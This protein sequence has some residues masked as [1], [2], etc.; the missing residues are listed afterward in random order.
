[1]LESNQLIINAIVLFEKGYFDCAY[2][3]LRQ[4]LE[5]ATT[6][7]YLTELDIVEKENK[8]KEWK[9]KK[10]FPM[11]GKMLTFLNNNQDVY[12]DM[13]EKMEPF[14]KNLKT[15]KNKMNKYV[16][17][18]GYDTFY[19]SKIN[20]QDKKIN[21][22]I[23]DFND[24]IKVCIGSIA[25][26]RLSIDP[27][28]ILLNDEDMYL[29]TDDLMTRG[30]S[31][32]FINEY[33]GNKNIEN[34]KKTK[35]FKEF[36]DDIIK[37]E[38]KLHSVAKVAKD[39]YINKEKIPEILTQAHLL[40]FHDRVAVFFADISSKVSKIYCFGG[41]MPYFTNTKTIRNDMSWSSEVFNNFEKN[42]IHHNLPYDE[43]FI[44]LQKVQDEIF[45]IEHNELFTQEELSLLK[46]LEISA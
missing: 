2:Y 17:K 43:A 21:N 35:I 18:Q 30:Y 23:K 27:F 44:T 13:Y 11:M 8:L 38:K 39:Q 16:H 46:I 45:F 42:E 6:M 15:E 32:D 22:S 37:R 12:R 25:V 4:S 40:S 3:S 10:D 7:V 26:L 33:I 31:E 19:L 24:S 34:Y 41:L 28:P 14:F 9:S 20:K 5:L 29:R 1:M 36:Y